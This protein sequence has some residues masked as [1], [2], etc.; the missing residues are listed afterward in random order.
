M[1]APRPPTR[2]D[3]VLNLVQQ[4]DHLLPAAETVLQHVKEGR[5]HYAL[6]WARAL[7]EALE[8]EQGYAEK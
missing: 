5:M 8:R 2:A 1:P 3:A 7:V 4:Q 6:T